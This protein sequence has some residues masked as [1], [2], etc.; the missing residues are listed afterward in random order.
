VQSYNSA[1]FAEI[2]NSDGKLSESNLCFGESENW[3][4]PY[5]KAFAQG[6]CETY[7][8]GALMPERYLFLEDG[9]FFYTANESIAIRTPYFDGRWQYDGENLYLLIERKIL[10]EGGKIV[11]NTFGGGGSQGSWIEGGTQVNYVLDEVEQISY[12][13]EIVMEDEVYCDSNMASVV[14]GIIALEGKKYY[15]APS[16]GYSDM[17][18]FWDTYQYE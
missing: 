7:G 13:L 9:R 4:E 1:S 18:I 16:I 17:T 6:W 5:P 11:Q 10:I 2:N 12:S 3:Q 8:L 14:L 15:A